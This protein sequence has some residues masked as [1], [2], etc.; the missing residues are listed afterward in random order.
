[1]T[2]NW[3]ELLSLYKIDKSPV[4]VFHFN[5]IENLLIEHASMKNKRKRLLKIRFFPLDM[6]G[7]DQI[8]SRTGN[9][10]RLKFNN[11]TKINKP[12]EQVKERED[13]DDDNDRTSVNYQVRFREIL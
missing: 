10:R 6:S 8:A 7:Y 13:D 5:P 4:N 2:N 1:M 3:I 12:A 9:K 11:D